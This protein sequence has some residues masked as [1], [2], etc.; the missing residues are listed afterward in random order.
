MGQF[1]DRYGMTYG[2]IKRVAAWAEFDENRR[3]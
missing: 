3:E 1:E 2:A